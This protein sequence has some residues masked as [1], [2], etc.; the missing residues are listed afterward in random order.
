MGLALVSF[1]F[2]LSLLLLFDPFD[3]FPILLYFL[4]FIFIFDVDHEFIF[5]FFQILS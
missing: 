3:Q 4:S 1:R 2:F 5:P